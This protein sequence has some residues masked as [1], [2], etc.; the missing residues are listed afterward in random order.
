MST[1]NYLYSRRGT[2]E[3]K[4]VRPIAIS[5]MLG[6]FVRKCRLEYIQLQFEEAGLLWGLFKISRAESHGDVDIS[7]TEDLDESLKLLIPE[8]MAG[9][10]VGRSKRNVG[11]NL[12]RFLFTR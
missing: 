8:Y 3:T 10:S 2:T 6:R 4:A 9:N 1:S 12:T 11:A 5:S 7:P